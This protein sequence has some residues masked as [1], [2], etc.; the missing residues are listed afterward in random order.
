MNKQ[1]VVKAIQKETGK[2]LVDINAILK[3]LENV[4]IDALTRGERVQLT[5]FVTFKPVVRQARKG[6]DPRK[7]E[8]ID[9]PES[10]GIKSVV[11]EKVAAIGKTLSVASI[12]GTEA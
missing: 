12:K 3:S 6:F 11:G 2:T 1:E 8:S 9:I 4:T 7:R 5:G 10:V